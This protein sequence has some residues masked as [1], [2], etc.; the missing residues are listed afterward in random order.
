[1]SM[2]ST[3]SGR[4]HHTTA[5]L[6]LSEAEYWKTVADQLEKL[7]SMAATGKTKDHECGLAVKL[8]IVCE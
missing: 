7:S 1:M 2:S 6:Q 8:Y 4:V 3:D 5:F